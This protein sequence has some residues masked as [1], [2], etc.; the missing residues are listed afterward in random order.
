MTDPMLGL[1]TGE[2]VRRRSPCKLGTKCFSSRIITKYTVGEVLT[3]PRGV[4]PGML[5]F[6]IQANATPHSLG[7]AMSEPVGY[8]PDLTFLT[9]AK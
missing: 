1:R 4:V 6:V 5:E 9:C 8:V 3:P 7:A 2:G